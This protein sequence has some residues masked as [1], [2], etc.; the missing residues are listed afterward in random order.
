MRVY[1]SPLSHESS[2]LPACFLLPCE[3]VDSTLIGRRAKACAKCEAVGCS[4]CYLEKGGLDFLAV[5]LYCWGCLGFWW[6]R[7]GSV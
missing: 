1:P 5:F 7:Q 6:H 3:H 4:L 2:L